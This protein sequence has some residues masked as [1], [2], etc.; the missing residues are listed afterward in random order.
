MKKAA[1]ISGGVVI[2]EKY[3]N[4]ANGGGSIGISGMAAKAK[5]SKAKNIRMK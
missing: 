3:R 1:A 5:A 4:G 2:G